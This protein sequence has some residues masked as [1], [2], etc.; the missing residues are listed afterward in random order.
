MIKNIF[1]VKIIIKNPPMIL[2]ED[3]ALSVVVGDLRSETKGSR[4]ESGC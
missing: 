3:W 4:L 2:L 1:E